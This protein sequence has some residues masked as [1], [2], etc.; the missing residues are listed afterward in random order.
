MKHCALWILKIY[1]KFLTPIFG[2]GSCRYYPTCS[3]YARWQFTYNGFFKAVIFSLLRILRCNQLF[4]GG[5][6]Y[7]I[8]DKNRLNFSLLLSHRLLYKDIVFWFVPKN[9]KSFYLV[10]AF[11]NN[12]K[13]EH[14]D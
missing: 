11:K 8:L 3:E 7:P 10:K 6:D 12:L 14:R 2:Y 5:I 1:Q 4:D 9:K 13:K